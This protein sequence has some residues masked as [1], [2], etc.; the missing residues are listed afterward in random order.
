MRMDGECDVFDERAHLDGEH[1]FRYEFAGA[2]ADNSYPQHALGLRIDDQLG[3]AF[4][5]VDCHGASRGAP[6]ESGYL[7]LAIFFL[8]LGLG[9]AA[10]GDLWIGEDDGG[11]CVGF[12]GDFMSSDGFDR[13]ASFMRGLVRQHGFAHDVADGVNGG[14]VCL[15]L[16]IYLNETA[17][18]DFDL[19]FLQTRDLGIR[20]A[21]H[22][23]QDLVEELLAFF[24]LGAVESDADSAGFFFHGSDGGVEQDGIKDLLHSLMQWEHEIAIRSW[25][26]S[27]EHLH[28]GDF[29]A[30]CGVDCAEF[31]TEISAT[32]HEQSAG[33]FAQVQRGS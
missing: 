29:G 27:G 5:S 11:N 2:G 1:S 31:Q 6:G 32:D 20:L 13:G 25:E 26:K 14:I 3:H 9:E 12:E 17:L 24:Y 28:D 22:R 8:R 4:S 15:Q 21:S 18:A 10:P 30:E 16:L 33:Y 19:S 7:D 23:N